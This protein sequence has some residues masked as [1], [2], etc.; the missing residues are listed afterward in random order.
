ML[1]PELIRSRLDAV[2][3]A[4]VG[5]DRLPPPGGFSPSPADERRIKDDYRAGRHA[6]RKAR[7]R[8]R[9]GLWALDWGDPE[10]AQDC[11]C[12]AMQHMM[13]A[14]ASVVT[15]SQS[16]QLLEPAGARGAPTSDLNR[17][18]VKA[19]VEQEKLGLKGKAARHAALNAAP[20]LKAECRDRDLT[21]KAMAKMMER[22]RQPKT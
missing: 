14:L 11:L 20:D 17:R 12:D 9:E 19:I 2:M 15:P 6:L 18:L 10:T 8:A 13:T 22:A 3:A 21:D 16:S 5:A 1:C 7:I 4:T